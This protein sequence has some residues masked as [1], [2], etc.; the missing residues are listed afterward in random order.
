[1]FDVLFIGFIIY[2]I[3]KGGLSLYMLSYSGN[4]GIVSTSESF[5]EIESCVKNNIVKYGISPIALKR[6][7]FVYWF[8]RILGAV[9]VAFFVF[10][11]ILI[12]YTAST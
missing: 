5:K 4:T 1:M 10:L 2:M 3:I 9:F 6:L 11:I 7:R 12:I 8:A